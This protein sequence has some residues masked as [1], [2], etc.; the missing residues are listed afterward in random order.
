MWNQ[1]FTHPEIASEVVSPTV[2][3]HHRTQFTSFFSSYP[4]DS[5]RGFGSVILE[6]MV[7]WRFLKWKN[8]LEGKLCGH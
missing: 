4:R 2:Y 7:F 1:G 3:I 8:V 6:Y 5:F